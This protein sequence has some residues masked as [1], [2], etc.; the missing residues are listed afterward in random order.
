MKQEKRGHWY[1]LTGLILGA[2]AGLL[3]SWFISPVQYIDTE[4]DSLS[5]AYKDEYRKVIALAYEANQ[6][7]ARARVRAYL[8]DPE[9][10]A[11]E[12]AA[13][14][15]RLIA[16]N[17][18]PR[19]ARALAVL[20]AALNQEAPPAA[21]GAA[22]STPAEEAL[23]TASE[24]AAGGD[25]PAT[26]TVDLAMAVQTAT[27]PLP[28]PTPT[29]TITPLPTFTARPTAT[30]P[31]VQDAPF[32]L[33]TSSEICPPE[34]L[35]GLLQVEVRDGSGNPLPGVRIQVTWAAGQESFFTGLVPEVNPGYA[36]YRMQPGATYSVVVGETSREVNGIQTSGNCG[37]R[38]E[39]T[40]DQ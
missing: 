21:P 14:A 37:R 34:A 27:Q 4:P 22:T 30:P 24:T 40:Q 19:E 20:A 25:L 3:Y 12:M 1:L 17:I 36:D 16:A 39:F 18:A 6:D 5:A 13:Q 38:L 33:A 35:P 29:V 26:S 23:L 28:S 11:R 2:A 9:D 31:Q 15:Q 7:L 32:A 8:V 10:P